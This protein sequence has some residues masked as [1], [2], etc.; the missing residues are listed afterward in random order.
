ML[1]DLLAGSGGTL[2]RILSKNVV[3]EFF[4]SWA[5]VENESYNNLEESMLRWNKYFPQ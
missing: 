3:S 4:L 2:V 1:S 5:V